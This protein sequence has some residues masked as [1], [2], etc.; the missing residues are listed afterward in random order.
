MSKI[1]EFNKPTLIALRT[2]IDAALDA[3]GAKHGISIKAGS[4]RFT[5]DNA[6]FKL[7]CALLNSEG[8]AESKELVA[9]KE[10]YPELVNKSISRGRKLHGTIIGYN[11]R[12]QQYPFLLQTAK[13]VYKITALQ[14]GLP[15]LY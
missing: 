15:G 11:P 14:A 9:L 6:T 2:D 5:G 10:C 7:E 12:A 3:V 13:G 4:A 1:T 8:I